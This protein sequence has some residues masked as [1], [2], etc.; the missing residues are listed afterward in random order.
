MF[1]SKPC[2]RSSPDLEMVESS[3]DAWLAENTAPPL[4]RATSGRASRGFD[5]IN[6]PVPRKVSST[7][8]A[9]S[10]APRPPCSPTNHVSSFNQHGVLVQDASYPQPVRSRTSWLRSSLTK[11]LSKE[12]DAGSGKVETIRKRKVEFL[13]TSFDLREETRANGPASKPTW[14]ISNPRC[15]IY[16][17]GHHHSPSSRCWDTPIRSRPHMASRSSPSSPRLSRPA[18]KTASASVRFSTAS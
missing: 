1:F 8:A 18:R 3:E 5:N 6:D 2:R 16:G 14:P 4:G 12:S 10:S 11:N 13:C 17:V 9:T 15:R 7:S